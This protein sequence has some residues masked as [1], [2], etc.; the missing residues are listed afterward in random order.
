MRTIVIVMFSPLVDPFLGI[1]QAQ[2][3]MLVETLLPERP[4]K[5]FDERIIC[6]LSRTAEVELNAVEVS[7][8]VERLRDEFRSV[9][10]TDG[11]RCA[12]QRDDLLQAGN[13]IISRQPLT[14]SNREALTTKVIDYR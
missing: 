13:D 2:E 7:S 11:L 12:A 6:G 4:I 9:V 8:P 14:G 10:D 5:R 1:L 3:P